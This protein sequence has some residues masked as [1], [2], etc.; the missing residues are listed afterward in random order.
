MRH[1]NDLER[2]RRRLRRRLNHARIDVNAAVQ[3]AAAGA[4][5][6]IRSAGEQAAERASRVTGGADVLGGSRPVVAKRL[7]AT[8]AGVVLVATAAAAGLA[9]RGKRR[10]RGK[11]PAGSD[12]T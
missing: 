5:D 8:G 11:P 9:A 10:T 12:P 6:T 3:D 4:S 2:T 7:L 1:H